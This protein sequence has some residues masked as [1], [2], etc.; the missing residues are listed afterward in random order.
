MFPRNYLLVLSLF[1]LFVP[2]SFINAQTNWVVN[3]TDD[4]DDGTCDAAHCSLREAI[5]S[6]NTTAGADIIGFAIPGAAPYRIEPIS[7]LPA[8]T[9][10][11][12]IIDGTT[13]T[14][15][16]LG[17]VVIDGINTAPKSHGLV[18]SASNTEIYGLK[19]VNFD[20]SNNAGI[21]ISAN[22]QLSDII[23]GAPDKSNIV[24]NCH[25]GIF[26][27]LIANCNNVTIQSNYVGVD[28]TAGMADIG[29]TINGIV[30]MQGVCTNVLIGGDATQGE[31]NVVGF[32]SDGI[33]IRVEGAVV[34]GNFVGTDE[35][36]TMDLGNTG[37]GINLDDSPGTPNNCLIGGDGTGQGN[38]VAFNSVG[39]FK[40]PTAAINRFQRNSFFCNGTGIQYQNSTTNGTAP[41]AVLCVSTGLV[42]GKA[43]PNT[44]IEVFQ[45]DNTACP[46][47]TSCQGTIYL[48]EDVTDANGDWSVPVSLNVGDVVGATATDLTAN[49]SPFGN[50]TIVE[51]EIIAVASNS[52]PF[53]QNSVVEL[54]GADQ[55]GRTGLSFSWTGP[56]NYTANSQNPNTATEPGMYYLEVTDNTCGRSIDST[57]VE[58]L[59]SIIVTIGDDP[60]EILCPDGSVLV[61]G[62][63]YDI[64]NP[65]GT[66][67]QPGQA[68]ACDT[69][70]NVQLQ[71]YPAAEGTL[72]TMICSGST[73]DINGNQYDESNPTGTEILAGQAANGCDSMLAVNVSFIAASQ[74]TLDTI[75]CDGGSITV[76]GTVYDENNTTG[77]ETLMGQAANGCDSIVAVN[78]SFLP[79]AMG[80]LDTMICETSN[81]LV[82]GTV[83]DVNNA[84]GVERLLGV[85]TDGCDSML[86]VSLSFIPAGQS[87][88]DTTVCEG[89][90]VLFNGTVYDLN[91]TSG[92]ER[93]IG[94][95][96]SGCDSIVEVNLSFFPLAEG[97]LDTTICATADFIF[98]G[99]TYDANNTMGVERLLGEAANGCDSL[100][101]VQ[102][103]FFPAAEGELLLTACEGGSV[104]FNGTDYDASNTSGTEI[105]IGQAA[106]GCDSIVNVQLSFFP[107]A[108]SDFFSTICATD[109]IVVNGTD[110]HANNTSGTELLV[111]QAVNGCDSTVNV[112][113]DFF[114]AA[115]GVFEPVICEGGSILFNGTEYDASNTSGTE[116][117]AGQ[118]VNGCDSIVAVTLSFFPAANGV[119]EP[120]VCDGGSILFNGTTYDANNS[121]GTEVLAGQAANGCDSIVAVTLSFSPPIT[122]TLSETFCA[123][124]VLMV[125]GTAYD[126]N[127]PTGTEVLLGAAANGCDSTVTIALQFITT[128][129]VDLSQTLCPGQSIQ[130][131]GQTYDENNPTGTELIP[132]GGG[133]CDSLVTIDLSFIPEATGDLLLSICPE[134][135]VSINGTIYDINNPS[136]TEVLIGQSANGCDSILTVQLTFEGLM[137]NAK[138]FPPSCFGEADGSIN[139]ESL[140]GGLAPYSISLNGGAF[141]PMTSFPFNLSGLAAG[142]Y[143]I[144]IRDVNDCS[145][146][147][148]INVPVPTE[149]E[150]AL[151]EDVSIRLGDSVQL[152][153][154]TN[155]PGLTVSWDPPTDLSCSDCLTPIAKPLTT[156]IYRVEISNNNNCATSDDIR[157]VVDPDPPVFVANAFS[158]NGDGVNDVFQVQADGIIQNISYF[159]VFDRWGSLLFEREN[160]TPNSLDNAW[161]GKIRGQTAPVG[162]YVYFVEILQ[163]NGRLYRFNGDVFLTR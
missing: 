88:L 61:N 99:T 143:N 122:S 159:R 30:V 133:V 97:T 73:I 160:F 93:L 45:V 5:N 140:T 35:T 69:V 146:E 32:N 156:T 155:L 149:L 23:I 147:Q 91:N 57:L 9:D 1:V 102:V 4:V 100:V 86:N 27:D 44:I 158:P 98:N 13:Q 142:D 115:N 106:N 37:F 128:V 70:L 6:A 137:A 136:G 139:V 120:E 112:S 125:N 15:Y 96:A 145:I 134:S 90:T 41:P 34:Q 110:Y 16:A 127:N 33:R 56:N 103:D 95:S 108:E 162:V 161:D 123:G 64:N 22:N 14:A 2:V 7:P 58:I 79:L 113:I 53:C 150:V 63:T 66:E 26:I 18:V 132:G 116:I 77:S 80:N 36:A 81:I 68:G 119:F 109:T 121:T 75:V 117:L 43:A 124:F 85:A 29:N 55:T 25:Q 141:S 3:S 71:F 138:A 87:T 157:I 89:G 92:T 54:F 107:P 8:L 126:E 48:G 17:D 24:G 40:Y 59:P 153:A 28:P 50:C 83:Y 11:A 130:V 42:E 21:N 51:N 105:L 111:G 76:N 62:T 74:A 84:S 12:T 72:D 10:A 46:A 20:I 104:P 82:N 39:I 38:T 52:G 49:T 154:L 163:P 152:E 78:L 60:S 47:N 114:P 67:M 19:I 131:N 94:Q 118:A 65:M 144:T 129:E 148:L 31:G 135:E 151:G 101:N